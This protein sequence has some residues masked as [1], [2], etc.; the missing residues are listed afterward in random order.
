MTEHLE[1]QVA[2][3]FH[4][5]FN[6]L[7]IESLS[8]DKPDLDWLTRL[9]RELRDRICFLTPKR[10]DIHAELYENLDSELF[11]QMIKNEAYSPEDMWKLVSYVFSLLKERE[12]PARNKS[13]DKLIES[14][15]VAFSKEGATIATFVPIFLTSAHQKIDEIEKDKEEFLKQFKK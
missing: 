5:A 1:K 14:L 8:G 12:A 3:Q 4:R 10:K 6:D 2:D 15:Y 9:H 11:G 13:T 7:L